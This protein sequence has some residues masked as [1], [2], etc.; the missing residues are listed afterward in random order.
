MKSEIDLRA[1]LV[2]NLECLAS[3]VQPYSLFKKRMK[4][5]L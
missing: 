4:R 1:L 3:D 5:R 2:D